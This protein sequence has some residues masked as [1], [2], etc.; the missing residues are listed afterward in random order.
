M[1]GKP[2]NNRLQQ[3]GVVNMRLDDSDPGPGTLLNVACTD[4][5][6][7][8][9]ETRETSM[10]DKAREFPRGKLVDIPDIPTKD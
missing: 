2:G 8:Q 5:N 7:R 1:A 3:R 10:Y 9:G 6:T 4:C